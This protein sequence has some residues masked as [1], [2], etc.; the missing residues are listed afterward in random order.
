MGA[1]VAGVSAWFTAYL[2]TCAI[3]IPLVVALVRGMG[4]G[5]DLSRPVLRIAGV[6]WALQLTHPVLWLVHPTRPVGI[7]VAEVV[8]V[9]VESLALYAWAVLRAWVAPGVGAWVRALLVAVIANGASFAL[10]LLA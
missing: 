3:E 7:L 4:W 9:A 6:A 10:G 8:I 2:L 5:G 1:R